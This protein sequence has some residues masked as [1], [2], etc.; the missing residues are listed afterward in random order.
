MS[1]EAGK[2]PIYI[3]KIHEKIATNEN[4]AR[5]DADRPL[6]QL[7]RAIILNKSKLWTIQR[8]N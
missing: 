6:R 5:A 8:I 7:Q 4:A 1:N 2:K 3:Q